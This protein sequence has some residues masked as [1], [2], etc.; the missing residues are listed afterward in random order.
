MSENTRK[1]ICITNR[2]LVRGDFCLWL[3]RVLCR[4]ERPDAVVLREKDLS[5]TEYRKLA[6][7]AKE[8][9][10]AKGTRLIVNQFDSI[11]AE[12][13][14]PA[15]HLPYGRFLEKMEK[16]VSREELRSRFERIGTSVHKPDEAELAG[17]LGAD[18]V[19]AGH[20][21]QTD[22]KKGLAPRGLDFLRAC[23][24]RVQIPVYAIGGIPLEEEGK[25]PDRSEKKDGG[26][27]REQLCI[28]QGAAGVCIMSDY[29]RL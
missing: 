12:L 5:E 26:S 29:A 10:Q 18:Y 28:R 16:D 19:F 20:I 1:R 6:G 23:C 15:I 21:F 7:A 25:V 9:C 8:I 13:G 27:T 3:E 14:I 4:T 24:E 22:C 17:R 11:A 2:H